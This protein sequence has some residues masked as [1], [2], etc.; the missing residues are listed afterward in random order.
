MKTLCALISVTGLVSCAAPKAVVIDEP[1]KAS[2]EQTAV[3]G[4]PE[5]VKVTPEASGLN[6]KPKLPK[7]EE[8]S[9]RLPD[10]LAMPDD[11]QLRTSAAGPASSRDATVITRPPGE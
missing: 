6:S 4:A 9:I 2:E 7:E 8:I 10:M 11:E 5:A 3:K 1:E